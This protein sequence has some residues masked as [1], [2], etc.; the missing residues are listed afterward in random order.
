MSYMNV[1]SEPTTFVETIL[2]KIAS[3]PSLTFCQRQ[4]IPDDF[5]TIEDIMDAIEETKT[6]HYFAMFYAQGKGVESNYYDLKNETILESALNLSY[7]EVWTHAPHVQH[8]LPYSMII[9]TT[10]N[11]PFIKSPPY[12]GYLGIRLSGF[13]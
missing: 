12:N 7:P 10:L 4:N 9:C 11:L 2:P 3:L 1:L 8:D 5:E 13:L 6:R